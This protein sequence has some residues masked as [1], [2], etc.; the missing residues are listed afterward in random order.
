MAF[1]DIA[2]RSLALLLSWAL[3]KDNKKATIV[4]A[5]SGDTGGAVAHGFG[6][7]KNI[8]VIILYPKN[9]IS[10]LQEEQLTRVAPNVFSVEVNGVFDN[11]QSL[12]K[13]TFVDPDLKKLNLSSANSISVGRLIPQIIYYVY[14]Y[15]L[16]KE[17]NIEFVVPCGNFGNVCAGIMA[18]SMGLPFN[19]FVIVNNLNDPVLKYYQTEKFI[20]QPTVQTLSNAMDIGNPSNFT[21]I[22]EIFKHDYF[23]FKKVI[24]VLKVTDEETIATIKKVYFKYNYLLDPHTAV[25]WNGA[26]QTTKNQNIKVILS[27][28]SPV[29]FASIIKQHTGIKVDDSQAIK[30]LTKIPKR[31]LEIKNDYQELKKILLSLSI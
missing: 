10:Q 15:S 14:A 24:Q 6:N 8:N 19:K 30:E 9:K 12:V 26:Q 1:K 28:A 2:A 20:P 27:T 7:V 22:L 25:A 29:K 31:K 11:C 17:Q 3:E 18:R 21:R 13:K 5:T 4:V 16:I 23:E